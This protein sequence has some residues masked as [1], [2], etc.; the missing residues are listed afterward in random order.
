M[1]ALCQYLAGGAVFLIGLYTM[2]RR[3]FGARGI[4][5]VVQF[6]PLLLVV[7]MAVFGAFHFLF[8]TVVAGLVPKWIPGPL[9]WAYFVGVALIAAGVSIAS[10]KLSTLAASLLGLMLLLFVLLLSVP[11]VAKNPHSRFGW[12]LLLRD[13]S[14]SAGAFAVAISRRQTATGN[15]YPYL[16]TLLRSAVAVAMIF[17]AI[18]HFLHPQFVPVLPLQQPLPPWF[19]LHTVVN[20][21][22]GAA[23]LIA[24]ACLLLNVRSRLAASWIG[25]I[26]LAVVILVYLPLLIAT[27][28]DVGQVNYFFDT[29]AYAGTLLAIASLPAKQPRQTER[30]PD[31]IIATDSSA[32]SGLL[33][34]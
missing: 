24:G 10:D 3:G 5:A 32:Q 18:E 20:Y 4:D 13:M 8:P 6:G 12:A 33:N 17:F 27:P 14:F 28:T 25:T 19:P 9:F 34:P 7:P 2:F 31:P 22:V 16:S 15:T 29:L 23:L 1:K 21:V 26:A 11:G 30:A